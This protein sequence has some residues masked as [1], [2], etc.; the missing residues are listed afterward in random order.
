MSKNKIIFVM[1]VILLAL[2]VLGFPPTSK[3]VIS[4]IIGLVLVVLSFMV[5]AKRRA[6][7][8]RL[9]RS[10]REAHLA[11][12]LPKSGVLDETPVAEEHEAPDFVE[13]VLSGEETE[14]SDTAP[15]I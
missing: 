10:R 1:G 6:S 2:P 3:N 13:E 8:R 11:A 15:R 9:R 4:I 5:A 14:N 12:G 7:A